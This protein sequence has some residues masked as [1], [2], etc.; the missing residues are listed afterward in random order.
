MGRI[1]ADVSDDFEEYCERSFKNP[2]DPICRI[3]YLDDL[4][5]A[6]RFKKF[7]SQDEIRSMSFSFYNNDNNN[8]QQEIEVIDMNNI[9]NLKLLG[10]NIISLNDKK[11]YDKLA[12]LDNTLEY[13]A[14]LT[15]S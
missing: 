13:Y 2:S 15:E 9:S 4:K 3:D 12:D 8:Q 5:R 1:N 11:E 7:L 6:E 14:K 10:Y